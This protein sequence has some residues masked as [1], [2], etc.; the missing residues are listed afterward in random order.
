MCALALARYPLS[1]LFASLF[2]W[3]GFA[4]ETHA[5]EL[6]ATNL[7]ALLLPGHIVCRFR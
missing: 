1:V 2:M 6:A 4:A 7:P 5:P 3:H